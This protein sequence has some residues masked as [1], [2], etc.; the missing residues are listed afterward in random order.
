MR[1]L[2]GVFLVNVMA[3]ISSTCA[4]G[5]RLLGYHRVEVDYAIWGSGWA[6]RAFSWCISLLIIIFITEKKMGGN[7][8]HTHTHTQ[9]RKHRPSFS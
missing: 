6:R 2:D 8:T 9:E 5:G 1:G 3:Q 4:V 7:F